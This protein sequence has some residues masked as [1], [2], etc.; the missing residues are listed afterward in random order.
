MAK[1]T[2]EFQDIRGCWN[3]YSIHY[4]I[5]I[6]ICIHTY[7]EAKKLEDPMQKTSNRNIVDFS[8]W[9]FK[10]FAR[11]RYSRQ[12]QDEG[13]D[14]RRFLFKKCHGVVSPWQIGLVWWFSASPKIQRIP[15]EFLDCNERL[16]SFLTFNSWTQMSSL[17][18]SH[19][20]VYPGCWASVCKRVSMVWTDMLS[21]KGEND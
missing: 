4:I 11:Y 12:T 18:Y 9:S 14:W 13:F 17:T 8:F 1:M 5:Y 15:N 19:P 20:F 6:Y 10:W 3:M 16:Q 21:S 2:K 7:R